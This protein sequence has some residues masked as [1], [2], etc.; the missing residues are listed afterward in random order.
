[1]LDLQTLGLFD[2]SRMRLGLKLKTPRLR[3]LGLKL[4]LTMLNGALMK[5]PMRPRV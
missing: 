3:P 5:V 4:R 2:T 1:M